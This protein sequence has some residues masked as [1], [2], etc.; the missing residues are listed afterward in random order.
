[1]GTESPDVPNLAHEWLQ[2]DARGGYASGTVGTMRTRRYHALLLTSTTP[3]T[4]RMVLVNGIEA[5]IDVG[6]HRVPLSRQFYAPATL[7][8]G[9]ALPIQAFTPTPWPAWVFALPDGTQITQEILVDP[10]AGDTALRWRAACLGAMLHVRPLLSGRDYHTLMRENPNFDFRPIIAGGNVAWRPYAGLPAAACLTNGAYRHDP[11]WYRQ[12][13]YTEEQARG[14]DC[15]E[16][17][18]S[19]GVFTWDLG[20]GEAVMLLREGDGLAV[21]ATPAADRIFAAEAARRAGIADQLAVSAQ[22]YRV[23]RASGTSIVAGYPW[24]TDWGRDTFIALRGL[25]LGTGQIKQ[26]ESVLLAWCGHVS[27]G[28]LPNRFGDGD[29]PEY[30]TVDAS[31]WF[32][33]AVH[34]L[35]ATGVVGPGS[36][37][38]LRD[39]VEAILEGHAR[40]TRFGIA[41]APDGLLRAGVQG[42]QLT[43]MDAK[44]GDW[45]VT[46]RIGKPV[47]IQALWYNAL[48]IA[49]A[50]NPHWVGAAAQVLASFRS[51]FPDAQTGGLVDV[52]DAGHV[53]GAR[54]RAIRPNQIFAL[55]G[56]PFA[57]LA[58]QQAADVLRL[59]EAEL[60][61]PVGLRTL[62]PADPAYRPHYGGSPLERD[63]AY[64]QGTAWPWLMGPFVQA[65]LRV[66]GD[67][68]ENRAQAREKFL[69]P[70]LAHLHVAGLGHV[71]EVADGDAPHR[72]GGCPF[73]AWSLGEL[74]RVRNMTAEQ[75]D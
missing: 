26:A 5:W 47:E 53:A 9:E 44:V 43:W 24:F 3:P 10:V 22:A 15:I 42:Q 70:L 35:L 54:D 51:A 72:P 49:G 25:L 58:G 69:A 27:E 12:F 16:D 60:L 66:R 41:M 28:M 62:S 14:L 20:A 45:V 31:L 37:A 63:G 75:A 19:P 56:L 30:N 39:A 61:T 48:R 34:D 33:V 18:A 23:D 64:H 50:W 67:T 57:L 73:Q 36:Q 2:A 71:S 8:P 29:A 13:L 55:G 17:L 4:G 6:A 40:G 11:C 74:I 59:V 1:M 21:R 38:T 32:V 65:W 7:T 68:A 52:A 46:P